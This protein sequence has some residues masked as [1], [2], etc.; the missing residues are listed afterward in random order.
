MSVL[1]EYQKFDSVTRGS[2]KQLQFTT[3][4]LGGG[5][6]LLLFEKGN[7]INVTS[8]SGIERI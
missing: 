6:N 1:V 7:Q 2:V 4:S 8:L 3:C 5:K